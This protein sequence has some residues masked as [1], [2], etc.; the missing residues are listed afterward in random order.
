MSKAPTR[1]T[2]WPSFGAIGLGGK[3]HLKDAGSTADDA[4]AYRNAELRIVTGP[5]GR[6][7]ATFFVEDIGMIDSIS[8]VNFEAWS[9]HSQ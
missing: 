9:R 3:C 6:Q 5:K 1:A 4:P 7:T 2:K 8:E